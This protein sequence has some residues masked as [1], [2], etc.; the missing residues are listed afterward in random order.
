MEYM[1][2][3]NLLSRVESRKMVSRML[4]QLIICLLRTKLLIDK[5]S[6]AMKSIRKQIAK[7]MSQMVSL[8]GKSAAENFDG[9]LM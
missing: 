7:R 8:R 5:N 1:R 3:T 6:I 2:Q 4:A 9:L